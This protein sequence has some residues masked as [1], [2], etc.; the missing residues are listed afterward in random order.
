LVERFDYADRRAFV[1]RV[2]ADYYTQADTETEVRILQLDECQQHAAYTAHRGE[3]HVA[4]VATAFKKIKFYTRENVGIGEIHLPP[5]EFETEAC[6]LV[7]G[8]DLAARVGLDKGSEAGALRGVAELIQGLVPLFVR[9]DPGDVRVM[10]ELK[11]GHFGA[12]AIIIY[13]QVPDGVGLSERIFTVHREVLE[14]SLAVLRRCACRLGCP[15]CI[16]PSIDQGRLGKGKVE[17]LL[18]GMLHGVA[19]DAPR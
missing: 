9:V 3:V 5:E 8:P 18:Q 11:N 17:D 4:T 1:R 15:S 14:A 13:D 7:I 16:G 19:A 6:M 10:G 2:D 12:P